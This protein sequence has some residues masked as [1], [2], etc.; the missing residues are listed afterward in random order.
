MSKFFFQRLFVTGVMVLVA[1]VNTAQDEHNITLKCFGSGS[2]RQ[3]ATQVALRSALEQTYGAF[4]SSNTEIINDELIK[5]EITSVTNGNIVDYKILSETI[6]D[7]E[8]ALT[9]SATVSVVNLASFAQEKG[10]KIEYKGESFATKM[11]LQ[12]LNEESEAK[13]ILDVM[14]VLNE[15]SKKSFDYTISAGDPTEKV[16]GGE[17]MYQ[18]P[19]EV[20]VSMNNNFA[21]IS[22]Y[23]VSHLSALC[24]S[25]SEADSYAMHKKPYYTVNISALKSVSK[26]GK[27]IRLRGGVKRGKYLVFNFRSSK[28][29]QEISK[30]ILDFKY[31]LSNFEIND[32]LSKRNFDDF[33]NTIYYD[34]PGYPR[35][36]TKVLQDHFRPCLLVQYHKNIIAPSLF[37]IEFEQIYIQKTITQYNGTRTDNEAFYNYN[38]LNGIVLQFNKL[39]D[40][41]NLC[42]K[43]KLI[44]VK[45]LEELGKLKGYEIKSIK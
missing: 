1:I 7:E 22:D 35:R 5:D 42:V 20:S 34:T 3:E 8:Y 43:F 11:K 6:R 18:I 13:A 32:G 40:A 30:F 16:V 26:E 12:D 19:L 17:N 10:E 9:L 27:E 29:I 44:D 25:K 21:L 45:T 28:S 41:D 15:L 4:I 37:K 2:S 23:L 24:M 38:N 14:F 33:K 39:S 31:I 36:Y